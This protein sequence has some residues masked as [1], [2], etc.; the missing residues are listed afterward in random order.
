MGREWAF[1]LWA[2]WVVFA[3]RMSWIWRVRSSDTEAKR[4]SWRG[5][6]ETSLTTL[7]WVV[8]VVVGPISGLAFW[9]ALMSLLLA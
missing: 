9:K 7:S 4:E 5:W 1:T 8:Y 3:E 2:G 6:K